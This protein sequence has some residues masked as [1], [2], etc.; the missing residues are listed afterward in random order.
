VDGRLSLLFDI[1]GQ[2]YTEAV[3]T[4]KLI[5]FSVASLVVLSIVMAAVVESQALSPAQSAFPRRRPVPRGGLR[6]CETLKH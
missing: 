5:A 1:R 4:L 2:Q 3:G 6:S